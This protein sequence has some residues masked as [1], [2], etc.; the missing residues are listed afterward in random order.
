MRRLVH[1]LP[2]LLPLIAAVG[3]VSSRAQAAATEPYGLD[4]MA[5]FERL[6]FLKLDTLAGG[7]S[8]YDRSGGNADFS[9]FLYTNNNEK[10]L[11]DLTG[12]SFT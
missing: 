8:S 11:L 7:Q 4:A 6:P 2:A 5:H 12:V 3:V 1:Y 9:N 10:V